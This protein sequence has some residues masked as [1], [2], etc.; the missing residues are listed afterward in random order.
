MFCVRELLGKNLSFADQLDKYG[1]KKRIFTIKLWTTKFSKWNFENFHPLNS[2]PFVIN[3][4]RLRINNFLNFQ[5]NRISAPPSQLPSSSSKVTAL[6]KKKSHKHK[7]LTSFNFTNQE[8]ME[9]EG[10]P[11]SAPFPLTHFFPI[12][13][14]FYSTNKRVK[15]NH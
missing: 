12:Y 15:K 7:K 2:A 13:F 4:T 10:F 9:H 8:S 6:E 3:S 11:S 1:K 14:S 5:R